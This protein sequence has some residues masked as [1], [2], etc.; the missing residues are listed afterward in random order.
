MKIASLMA[1]LLLATITGVLVGAPTK[2]VRISAPERKE[3]PSMSDKQRETA[4]N[5]PAAEGRRRGRL[6]DL[7]EIVGVTEDRPDSEGRRRVTVRVR[8]VLVHYPKGVLTL[9][10]NLKSADHFV[11][12]KD[13][14]VLAGEEQVDLVATIVPV[15]WPKGQPFKLSVGLSAEPHPGQ[16][17]LLAAVTQVMKPAPTPAV[18]K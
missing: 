14:T 16:W 1:G 15:A 2:E 7:V 13:L 6:E 10:F 3:S 18:A 11:Q 8:Y 5:P 17:S 12:V 4:P 9:G